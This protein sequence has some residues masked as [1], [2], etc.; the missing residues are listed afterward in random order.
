MLQITQYRSHFPGVAS[1]LMDI[2]NLLQLVVLAADG[3]IIGVNDET[4]HALQFDIPISWC[5]HFGSFKVFRS[6]NGD[7]HAQIEGATNQGTGQK[8]ADQMTED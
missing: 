1:F 2:S 8:D 6:V 7:E 3:G 5:L 4:G